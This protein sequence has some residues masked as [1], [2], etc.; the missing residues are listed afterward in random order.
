MTD[1]LTPELRYAWKQAKAATDLFAAGVASEWVR[2]ALAESVLLHVAQLFRHIGGHDEDA[3]LIEDVL[4]A[5][6]QITSGHPGDWPEREALIVIARALGF[7]DPDFEP[8]GPEAAAP[9]VADLRSRLR[10]EI[11]W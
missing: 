9:E 1:T 2:N 4:T 11:G 6:T 5:S 3:A 10:A 7:D 8:Y